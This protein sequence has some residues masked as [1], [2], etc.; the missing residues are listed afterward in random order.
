MK[1]Y[2]SLFGTALAHI[3]AHRHAAAHSHH[4]RPD[5]VREAA[6]ACLEDTFRLADLKWQ[7]F[8]GEVYP[9]AQGHVA[10]LLGTA[11]P[12][13]VVF[14]ASTHELLVR[15]LSCCPAPLRILTTD[16]EFHS[17][18]RQFRRLEEA[19]RAR[20]TRVPAEPFD[21]FA[22]RFAAAA[23]G[24]HELV[25]LSHVFFDSGYVVPDLDAAF[26]KA[27]NVCPFHESCLEGRASGPA[28]EARWG[29]P[30]HELPDRHP[31]WELEAKYL[32]LGCLNLTAAWSPDLI[33]LGGGVSQ[34]AGLIEGVRREFT[35]LTGNYWSLPAPED[36]LRLPELDQQ[37]GI[38]GALLL[39]RRRLTPNAPVTPTG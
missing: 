3:S 38:V 12:E 21:S 37:A 19:Q 6:H 34:K 5:V 39:A 36:Y 8:L 33:I 16:S 35:V 31:A 29:L 20:V 11:Q 25:F 4:L 18:A 23:S 24:G 27:V 28:I 10:R 26:G 22:E 30:G 15:V 7:K 32:A 1:S 13:N 9:R 2:K 17:A 14:A